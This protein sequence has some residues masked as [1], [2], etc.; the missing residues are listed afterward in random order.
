MFR[1]CFFLLLSGVVVRLEETSAA[2]FLRNQVSSDSHDDSGNNK[3]IDI[4][5]NPMEEKELLEE[6]LLEDLDGDDDLV[7]NENEIETETETKE[8]TKKELLNLYQVNARKRGKKNKNT[9]MEVDGVKLDFLYG[10]D[11]EPEP[12]LTKEELERHIKENRLSKKEANALR[13]AGPLPQG[14]FKEKRRGSDGNGGVVLTEQELED[15]IKK[16]KIDEQEADVF[17]A[18]RPYSYYYNYNYG[19]KSS[20]YYTYG[21]RQRR[22][23]GYYGCGYYGFGYVSGPF[24]GGAR[25]YGYSY[26][27]RKSNFY[28][29]YGFGNYHGYGNNRQ[30]VNRNYIRSEYYSY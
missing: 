26:G 12:M 9:K 1:L 8:M 23:C 22:G 4:R 14:I 20:K 10:L 2:E 16:N 27:R 28:Y 15:V 24:G 19:G 5:L 17:R 21:R 30:Y 29:Y 7:V 25:Y 13:R 3:N 11:G 18:L 6:F